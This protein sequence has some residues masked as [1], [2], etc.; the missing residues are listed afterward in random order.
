MNEA[1]ITQLIARLESYNAKECINFIENVEKS[2]DPT[3][4]QKNHLIQAARQRLVRINA[5]RSI[6]PT[7]TP[8]ERA[9]F[10]ALA[11]YEEHLRIK[12]GRQVQAQLIKKAIKNHGILPAISQA[13]AKGN[14]LGFRS[15]QEAGLE[16]CSF[17]AVVLAHPEEFTPEILAKAT[18]TLSKCQSPTPH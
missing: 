1:R 10:Q 11:A 15:L 9:A 13:V 12:H 16:D 6:L 18:A 8:A 17:E 3:P 7:H 5:Q 2:P 14:T 4:E